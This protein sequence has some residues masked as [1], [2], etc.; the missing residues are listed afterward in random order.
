MAVARKA[1]KAKGK[2]KAKPKSKSSS[3][4]P[5]PQDDPDEVETKARRQLGRRDTEDAYD[6][7]TAG[8]LDHVDPAVLQSQKLPDGTTPKQFIMSEIRLR[9]A[10]NQRL[11]TT[12]WE[13]FFKTFNMSVSIIDALPDPDEEEHIDEGV[14]ANLKIARSRDTQIRKVAPYERYMESIPDLNYRTLY[15]IATLTVESSV[16]V[17]H[18]AMTLQFATLSALVRTRRAFDS[19]TVRNLS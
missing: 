3:V 6:R 1:A 10:A 19:D 5:V 2:P 4:A 14:L 8:R 11:S 15:G 12:F 7:V 9:R 16:V 13:G 18:N 17:H